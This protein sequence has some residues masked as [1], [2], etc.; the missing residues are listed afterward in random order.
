MKNDEFSVSESCKI[1]Q[2]TEKL[3]GH[4]N[5]FLD[6]GEGGLCREIGWYAERFQL[7]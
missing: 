4:S 7:G 3:V 5:L 1:I 6:A 2:K